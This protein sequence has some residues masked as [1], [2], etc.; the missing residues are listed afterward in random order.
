MRCDRK[1]NT[2]NDKYKRCPASSLNSLI[3]H[4]HPH[5]PT[6]PLAK[7]IGRFASLLPPHRTCLL[8]LFYLQP[9]NLPQR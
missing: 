7:V 9:S 8:H 3:R 6:L 1:K 2:R 4:Q 5:H